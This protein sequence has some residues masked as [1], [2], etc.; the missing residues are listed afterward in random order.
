MT[1]IH[2]FTD[3]TH[4]KAP[5][6]TQTLLYVTPTLCKAFGFTLQMCNEGPLQV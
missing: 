5:D 6:L 4:V 2:I 3:P 1:N